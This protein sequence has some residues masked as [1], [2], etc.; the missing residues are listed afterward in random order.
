MKLL[1]ACLLLLIPL[2]AAAK[3]NLSVPQVFEAPIIDGHPD[4]QQ[5]QQATDIT[6]LVQVWPTVTA[7][8]GQQSSFKLLFDAN[9]LYIAG[10]IR[11]PKDS[12]VANTLQYNQDISGDDRVT[13]LLDTLN[14]GSNAYWFAINP[15]G[16]KNDGLLV[17]NTQSMSE[18]NGVWQAQAV[19]SASGW[20]FE[21]AIP[22][23]LLSFD[24]DSQQWGMNIVQHLAASQTELR[25]SNVSQDVNFDD[26][27]QFGNINN[28]KIG[29]QG[30]GI[31]ARYALALSNN[32]SANTDRF[33]ANPSLDVFYRLT[34][35]VSAA[36]TLNTD[37][38]TA[39]VDR[40]R[41]NI[42]RFDLFMPENRDFFLQDAGIFEFGGL[43]RNGRP[44]FSRR[45]GLDPAGTPLDIKHGLKLSGYGE[46]WGLGLL[47]INADSLQNNRQQLSVARGTWQIDADNQAGFILTDGDPYR[48][49]SSQTY[50]LDYKFRSNHMWQNKTLEARF[51]AQK[52]VSDVQKNHNSAWGASLAY[53]NDIINFSL[54]FMQLQAQFRPALGFVN[55][56]NIRSYAVT[57]RY[58]HHLDRYGLRLIDHSTNIRVV[59][60]LNDKL[61]SS[62]AYFNFLDMT[63]QRGDF[64]RLA[65]QDSRDNLDQPFKLLGR[66]NIQ[67]DDYHFNRYWLMFDS[68]TASQFTYSASVNFGDFYHGSKKTATLNLNWKPTLHFNA[69]IK[70]R[71]DKIDIA[72]QQLNFG[73][74]SLSLDY[75]VNNRISW[76]NYFQYDDLSKKLGVSSRFRW[77]HSPGFETHL[78]FNA[79]YLN[80]QDGWQAETE[81]FTLRFGGYWRI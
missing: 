68:T 49:H 45:I 51:W 59:T 71:Y 50:G 74:Y 77:V 6:E 4:E 14:S 13:V 44:F 31:E 66:L 11:Q 64:I 8:H 1:S 32:K 27:A 7:S 17:N 2:L 75:I 23:N 41:I 22:F 30:K 43:T 26:P 47:T 60:D 55:R 33:E 40:R 67:A 54:D 12:I 10:S 19:Q 79:N 53:P 73:Q 25:W 20:S 5:W 46:D 16:V 39:D 36:L 63:S 37:F 48:D 70:L 62:T 21:M 3:P 56:N 80:Q 34:P 65:V 57:G 28:L 42:G 52:A 58:R 69:G 38:S 72:D 18:W 76:K 81:Q 78:V 61:K 15:N 35:S 24:P 29:T 9:N